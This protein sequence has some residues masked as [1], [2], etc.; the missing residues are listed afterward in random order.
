MICVVSFMFFS[1]LQFSNWSFVLFFSFVDLPKVT[2]RNVT[3][4]QMVETNLNR[5]LSEDTKRSATT[6][7]IDPFFCLTELF[8]PFVDDAT[9]AVFV[10]FF[11]LGHWIEFKSLEH[12]FF[13]RRDSVSTPKKGGR[14]TLAS[15]HKE[16]GRNQLHK[17]DT[18]V[19]DKQ[20]QPE[21]GGGESDNTQ[22]TKRRGNAAPRNRRRR[23]GSAAQKEE[24]K[25]APSRRVC[26][27]HLK[28]KRRR[29][30]TP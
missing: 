19:G 4:A 7:E 12:V 5:K 18:V 6:T 16:E 27:T 24:Q 14:E 28:R 10:L 26:I 9:C 21:E 22:K 23:E 8:F 25:T 29:R 30:E 11:G 2:Q 1:F 17:L 3:A 20:Y 15:V 13:G